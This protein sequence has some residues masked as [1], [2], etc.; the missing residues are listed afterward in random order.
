MKYL[1][2]IEKLKN[3]TEPNEDFNYMP[4]VGDFIYIKIVK[5]Y[6]ETYPEIHKVIATL[7]W[8]RFYKSGL[9][10]KR[11]FIN[12]CC[13]CNIGNNSIKIS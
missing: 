13:F 1:K 12:H 3:I 7:F 10:Q 11:L 8:C 2:Y 4:N 5:P 9:L 6:K